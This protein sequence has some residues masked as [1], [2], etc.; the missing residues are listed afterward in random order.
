MLIG[1]PQTI[2]TYWINKFFICLI[3]TLYTFFSLTKAQPCNSNFTVSPSVVCVGENTLL[4][5]SPQI[6]LVVFTW[7][8]DDCFQGNLPNTIGPHSASWTTPGTKTIKLQTHLPPGSIPLP[9]SGACPTTGHSLFYDVHVSGCSGPLTPAQAAG[10]QINIKGD[11]DVPLWAYDMQFY[12]V[13]PNNTTIR[14][15]GGYTSSN[16]PTFDVTFSSNGIPLPDVVGNDAPCSGNFL[17]QGGDRHNCDDVDLPAATYPIPGNTFQSVFTG[18]NPNG[19]WKLFASDRIIGGIFTLN[20]FTL[21][22]PGCGTF[23]GDVCGCTSPVT[24]QVVIVNP[25][26]S[27]DF[28]ATPSAVCINSSVNL[29]YLGIPISGASYNWNCNGCSPSIGNTFNPP[30]ISWSSTGTYSVTLSV[31]GPPP[32]NCQSPSTVKIVTVNDP[33]QPNFLITNTTVCEGQT[34]SLEITSPSFATGDIFTWNCSGCLPIIPPNSSGPHV[35]SWAAAGTKTITLHYQ[36]L[37]CP[38]V[39]ISKTVTVNPT[40]ASSFSIP[41]NACSATDVSLIYTGG[42]TNIIAWTWNCDDCSSP[43]LGIGPHTISWTTN[44]PLTKTVSLQV[45]NSHNCV[46]PITTTIVTV[47]PLPDPPLAN[48]LQVC[49]SGVFIFTITPGSVPGNVY[50]LYTLPT[51]GNFLTSTNATNTPITLQTPNLTTSTTQKINEFYLEAFNSQTNCKSAT[52]TFVTVTQNPLPSAP[53]GE[54]MARCS[55]GMVTVTA[56]WGTPIAG[57]NFHLH[58]VPSGGVPV[59]SSSQFTLTVPFEVV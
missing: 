6:G 32:S 59:V 9:G 20:C 44:T 7:D 34:T 50:R 22:I 19:T 33:P 2:K 58:T 21:T 54:I 28:A 16:C 46:S 12:L 41:A 48:N 43:P 49:G 24:T 18:V 42:S 5:G 8:C 13:A 15:Y 27:S 26:P 17:P 35:V 40:P 23:N 51:G 37:G 29:N 11:Y 14:L 36:R 1:I 38:V 56:Q 45:V 25:K 3:S 47:N 53:S 57:D 31:Q 55:G 10:I 52:R 4:Q 39:S 30:S